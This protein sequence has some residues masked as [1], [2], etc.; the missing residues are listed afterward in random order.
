MLLKERALAGEGVLGNEEG[1]AN[2]EGMT[3][4]AEEVFAIV[5]VLGTCL[6]AFMCEDIVLMEG[7]ATEDGPAA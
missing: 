6:G 1:P 2:S 4:M 5:A 7:P 3:L